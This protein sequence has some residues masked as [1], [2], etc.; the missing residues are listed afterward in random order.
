MP[1]RHQRRHVLLFQKKLVEPRNLRQHLQIGKIL[2][3][4]IPLRPLRMVPMLPKP[5]PQ[6]AV[7]RIP[8]NHVQRIRLKQILQREPPLVQRQILR[9]LGR[10]AQERILRRPR[11]VIL[12]LHHQRRH[13]IKVLVNVGKFIQQLH[14][15][16]VIFE[17]V[18]PRPRQTVLSRNQILIK[19]LV[20]V[21][22]KNDAQGR[23]GW[24]S[25]SSTAESVRS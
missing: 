1:L 5:F 24:S 15:A 6:L 16:V 19:R 22:Q 23:H 9:R 25:Q 10:D 2:R 18:Q 12:N 17:R 11:H 13:Q 14:H 7:P 20:L 8:P 21:P 3:L 4:K